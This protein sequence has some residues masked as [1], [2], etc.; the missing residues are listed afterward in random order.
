MKTELWYGEIPFGAHIAIWGF[1][2]LGKRYYREINT[3]GRYTV[4]LLVDRDFKNIK[5]E[6]LRILSP[7]VLVQERDFDYIILA[8]TDGEVRADMRKFLVGNGISDEKIVDGGIASDMYDFSVGNR[9]T[10]ISL[11]KLQSLFKE[12][13]IYVYGVGRR[14]HDYAYMFGAP[15]AFISENPDCSDCALPS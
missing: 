3:V 11:C 10:N 15:A 13:K 5:K 8:H 6:G 1:G 4:T 7:E 2:W 12:R 14:A 9:K